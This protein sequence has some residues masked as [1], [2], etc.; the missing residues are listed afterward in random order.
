MNRRRAL[1]ALATAGA[2][3]LVP[4]VAACRDD[5]QPAGDTG[6]DRPDCD[7]GDLIEGDKDCK[8]APATSPSPKSSKTPK[9]RRS[10]RAQ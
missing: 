2:L 1:T 10:R 4:A 8:P 6:R 7:L 9:P 5:G 3:L